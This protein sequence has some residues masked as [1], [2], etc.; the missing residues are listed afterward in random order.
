MAKIDQDERQQT[1]SRRNSYPY[2]TMI[3]GIAVAD[4]ELK[5]FSYGWNLY[6]KV[7]EASFVSAT[8]IRLQEWTQG[9]LEVLKDPCFGQ[10]FHPGI[11]RSEIRNVQVNNPARILFSGGDRIDERVVF[12]DK[13]DGRLGGLL[14]SLDRSHSWDH[15]YVSACHW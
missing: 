3:P 2:A 9:Y 12:S 13:I 10:D 8:P 7:D 15:V 1:L 6:K 11:A 5:R 4:F 14:N